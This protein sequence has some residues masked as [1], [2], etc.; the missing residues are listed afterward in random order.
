MNSDRNIAVHI[1]K[2]LDCEATGALFLKLTNGQLL[3]LFFIDGQIQSM[4]F[5]GAMGIDVLSMLDSHDVIK[6]QFHQG[7]ISRVVNQLP[8]TADII[9]IIERRSV[10]ELSTFAMSSSISPNQI[11]AIGH[12]FIAFVGPIGD[13]IFKEEL[14]QASSKADLINRLSLQLDESERAQFEREVN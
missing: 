2:Y 5:H 10:D 6:S 12:R 11:T 8:K 7:A 9:D 3:Q 13:M 1:Q 14:E 4:K